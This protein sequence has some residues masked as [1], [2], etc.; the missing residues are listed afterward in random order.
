MKSVKQLVLISICSAILVISK[1][2]L[3]FLPNI[4]L[5]TFLLLMYALHFKFSSALMIATVFC[6]LQIVLYGFGIW[7]PMYFIVW[8]G[9]VILCYRLK[10]YLT[11]NQRC[12]FLS[13][14]FGLL[15]GFLFSI[16]Y[17]FVSIHFGWTY[18][19]RGIPFDCIHCLGNYILMSIL[20]E[21]VSL[22]FRKYGN[23]FV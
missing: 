12:A 7:T 15:F 6:F 17:F 18:F 19:I 13:A 10:K 16:P 4:E 14:A 22:F 1:E 21:P 9:W 2:C 5:V 11:T 20:Y 23:K 8:N 3:A